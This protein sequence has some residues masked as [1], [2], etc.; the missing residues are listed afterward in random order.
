M[1]YLK[2]FGWWLVLLLGVSFTSCSS[3]VLVYPEPIHVEMYDYCDKYVTANINEDRKK[4]IGR[5]VEDFDKS[6]GLAVGFALVGLVL[7]IILLL[8]TLGL[9]LWRR[10]K[11]VKS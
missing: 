6:S 4:A 1:K 10:F 9:K 7:G 3:Y 8:P 11:R 2:L 5:C